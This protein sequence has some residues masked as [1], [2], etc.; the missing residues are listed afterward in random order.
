MMVKDDYDKSYE[1]CETLTQASR[2]ESCSWLL[3]FLDNTAAA[4][5]SR[6]GLLAVLANPA[7]PS[8]SRAGC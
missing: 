5:L 6:E 8:V 1:Y 4:S 2:N 7:A 3:A